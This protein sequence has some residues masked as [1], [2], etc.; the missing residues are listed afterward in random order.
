MKTAG[1]SQDDAR[2]YSWER[3]YLCDACNAAI[4]KY[5]LI[6]LPPIPPGIPEKIELAPESPARPVIELSR[7]RKTPALSFG[8]G[9]VGSSPERNRHTGGDAPADPGGL[10][11]EPARAS[12]AE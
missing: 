9:R 1:A 4:D 11:Q 3:H 8:I 5:H 2:Q 6:S 12:V 10:E 7:R